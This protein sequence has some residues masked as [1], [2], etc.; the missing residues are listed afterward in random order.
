MK[1]YE[2]EGQKEAGREICTFPLIT[3]I[4][5]SR[6]F[7]FLCINA[8]PAVVKKPLWVLEIN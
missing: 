5:R 1:R 6:S 7:F 3:E 2:I 8:S 4:F